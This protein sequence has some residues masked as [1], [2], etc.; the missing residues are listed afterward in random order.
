MATHR[1]SQTDQLRLRV[2]CRMLGHL[3]R[4][5]HPQCEC[6]LCQARALT[7]VEG[8]PEVG[9]RVEGVTP[10]EGAGKKG[11]AR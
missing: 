7:E 6:D 5:H 4:G 8:M 9:W 1:L 2:A 11:K 3:T 10:A